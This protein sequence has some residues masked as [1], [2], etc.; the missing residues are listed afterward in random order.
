MLCVVV[1]SSNALGILRIL[2]T[3]SLPRV[4]S[5]AIKANIQEGKS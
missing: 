4:A 1:Q 2:M 3:I 5:F